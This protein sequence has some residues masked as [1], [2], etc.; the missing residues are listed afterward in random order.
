MRGIVDRWLEDGIPV[1]SSHFALMNTRLDFSALETRYPYVLFFPQARTEALLEEHAMSLG[2]SVLREHE[3]TG[4]TQD[5][6][7]VTVTAQTP[8]GDALFRARYVV[9]CEGV[10]SPVRR[11][12]GTRNHQLWRS[13]A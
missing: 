9:G 4:L 8:G 1:P 6:D 13:Y 10:S 12:A 11:S 3:V 5:D 2:A 7:G